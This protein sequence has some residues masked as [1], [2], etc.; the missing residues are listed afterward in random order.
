MPLLTQGKTNWTFIAIVAIVA[1]IAGIS[2]RN[3]AS[4]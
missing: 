2:M 4:F 3:M 1:V